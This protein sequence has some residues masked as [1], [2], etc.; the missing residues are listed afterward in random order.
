MESAIVLPRPLSASTAIQHHY[1]KTNQL[2]TIQYFLHS[3][4][5]TGHGILEL[6]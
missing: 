1:I 6:A 3:P 5:F 4:S 2:A